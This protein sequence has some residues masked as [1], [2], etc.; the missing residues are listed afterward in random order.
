[1]SSP[2]LVIYSFL[3]AQG[4]EESAAW[5]M[6]ISFLPDDEDKVIGIFD[7]AGFQD[8]R[9]MADGKQIIHPG[10]QITVR[11][12]EYKDGWDKANAIALLLDA[13]KKVSV[14]VES[15]GVYTLHNVSRRGDIIPIGTE[16]IN[17]RR[18]HVFTMNMIATISTEQ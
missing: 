14:A 10:V 3:Q 18:R 7:T 15:D 2:S 4:V 5:K 6:Y 1:M 9:L 11:S 8:G 12:L 16:L 17:D 13:A